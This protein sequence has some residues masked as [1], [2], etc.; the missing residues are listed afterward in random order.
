LKR[1]GFQ[2]CCTLLLLLLCCR[3]M[4][5]RTRVEVVTDPCHPTL[6][7]PIRP[8]YAPEWT[9]HK[10]VAAADLDKGDILGLYWGD[11][12]TNR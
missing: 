12:K 3:E 6:Y 5:R 2:G 7:N 1:E 11:I 9:Q 8:V 10:L 4:E